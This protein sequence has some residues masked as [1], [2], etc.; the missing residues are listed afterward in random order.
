LLPAKGEPLIER[1]AWI[2]RVAQ[3]LDIPIFAILENISADVN[4]LP[5][6]KALLPQGQ[7]VFNKIV[8]GLY[9]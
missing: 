8:F 5:R 2:V 6:L 4:M 3:A 7:M 9:G 1:V